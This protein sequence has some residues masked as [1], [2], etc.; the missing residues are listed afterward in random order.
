MEVACHQKSKICEN[1]EALDRIW[2]LRNT[3]SIGTMET[4]HQDFWILFTM[5]LKIYSYIT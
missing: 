4:L 2:M 5:T 3:T 1:F